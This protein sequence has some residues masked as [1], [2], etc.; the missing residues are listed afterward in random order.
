MEPGKQRPIQSMEEGR[1]WERRFIGEIKAGRNPRHPPSRSI[2]VSTQLRRWC[3]RTMFAT[4]SGEQART[5]ARVVQVAASVSAALAVASRT[6]EG[7][8]LSGLSCTAGCEE[9][10]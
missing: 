4:G 5:S 2:N 8:G 1:D 6:T 3:L 10:L 9:C 7:C